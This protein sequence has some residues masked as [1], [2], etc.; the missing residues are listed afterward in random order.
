VY[1]YLRRHGESEDILVVH[2][3]GAEA[4][5][6]YWL[7]LRAS[8]VA[9][10]TYQTYDLLGE[11]KVEPLEVGDKGSIEQYAPVQ[12]LQPGQSMIILLRK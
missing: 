10:D 12:T 3:L 2:N 4:V 6:D 9:P 5:S 11:V 1:A 8:K 7:T